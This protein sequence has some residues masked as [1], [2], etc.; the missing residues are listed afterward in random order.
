MVGMHFLTGYTFAGVVRAVNRSGER[1]ELE[2]Y[3]S[4]TVPNYY[5]VYG[6]ADQGEVIKYSVCWEMPG[7]VCGVGYNA[8]VDIRNHGGDSLFYLYIFGGPEVQISPN[9]S[10][11]PSG[12]HE[13][14]EPNN[15]QDL[16][17][18][19]ITSYFGLS[20]MT[21]A[22]AMKRS[23][24]ETLKSLDGDRLNRVIKEFFWPEDPEYSGAN[25]TFS[26]LPNNGK[27]PRYLEFY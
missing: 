19:E 21:S 8:T 6:G 20:R 1:L 16:V 9:A 12:L 5:I 10:P 22:V 14:V 17:R 18:V 4:D 26:P 13:G 3:L 25:I 2:L 23:D 11:K 15:T 7:S 27:R 24:A